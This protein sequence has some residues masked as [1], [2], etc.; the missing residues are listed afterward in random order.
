M[1][2]FAY[3][4]LEDRMRKLYDASLN[5]CV[6]T[7]NTLNQRDPLILSRVLYPST[8][9]SLHIASLLGHLEFCHALLEINPDLAIE[10]NSEGRCPLHLASDKGHTEIVKFLWQ[11]N[12][13]TCLIRDKDDKLPLHYAAMRG[14]IGTINELLNAKPDSIWEMTEKD[15]GSIL[16]LCVRYNHLEA[17]KLLVESVREDNQF[18]SAKD[19]EDNTI[20][21]LAV[22]RRHIKIIEYLLSLSEMSTGKNSLNRE[23]LTSLDMLTRCPRDSISLRIEHMLTEA[24]VQRFA[25]QPLPNSAPSNEPQQNIENE[26]NRC[27]KWLDKFENFCTRYL[28][29]KGNWIDKKTREYL[30]VAATVIA[31]MTFQSVISPPG[32]VWQADTTTDGF[33]CI[34]YGFCEA[35]TAV[36]GY[37]QSPDFLKFIFFN[38]ASFFS[39]LCVLLI[40]ISG[41]PLDNKAIMW[42]LAV[43]M[44]AAVTCMLLTYMWALGLASPEHIYYKIRGLGYILVGTWSFLLVAVA[45]IQ[46]FRIVF[47]ARSRRRSSRNAPVLSQN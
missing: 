11:K 37:A 10:V 1:E 20:L 29:S 17:L 28:I 25:Q 3:L 36:L 27:K 31:T 12:P 7:L 43:L 38:S 18:L 23:G 46:T 21:H 33:A 40:L 22:K 15:D 5:G 8:D 14:R 39:S 30:M 41:F 42:I 6:S 13:E 9:T 2:D 4:I 35:G 19:K 47:W 45:L 26:P 34:E 16:H 24:G 32:G 44:I